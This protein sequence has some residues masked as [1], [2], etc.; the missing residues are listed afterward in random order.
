MWTK[1]RLSG[2]VTEKLSSVRMGHQP[3]TIQG[4]GLNEL[5]AGWQQLRLAEV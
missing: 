2:R 4:N 5:M 1:N 3:D